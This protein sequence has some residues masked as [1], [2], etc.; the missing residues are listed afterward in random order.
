MM[1]AAKGFSLRRSEGGRDD[2]LAGASPRHPACAPRQCESPRIRQIKIL[3]S[4]DM[5]ASRGEARMC[6]SRTRW[7]QVAWTRCVIIRTKNDTN[8]TMLLCS[9][10]NFAEANDA[11]HCAK[12]FALRFSEIV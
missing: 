5:T 8:S 7:R 1:D 3:I 2:L 4:N 11:Q 10:C 6:M 9:R 12:R